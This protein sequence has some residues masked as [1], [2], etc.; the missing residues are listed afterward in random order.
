MLILALIL[1]YLLGSI[2]VGYILSRAL[3]GID[4][5]KHGSGN[6][7]A[8]NVFRVVS[9]WAGIVV[10][11]LDAL[12]GTLP[13]T[14]LGDFLMQSSP[15]LDEVLVRLLLGV[16]AVCGHNW[17]LFLKFKGGKGVATSAG[18]LLGLSFKIPQLG[19]I[20]GLC[21]GVWILILLA[22][23]FVSLASIGASVA[24]PLFMLGFNQPLKLIIFSVALCLFVVYRHKSNIGRLL[25]K[26]EKKI[27]KS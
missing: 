4:I 3:K 25:R 14:V 20:A 27:F 17:T 8:T 23:G 24:L 12:K 16:A 11:V 15:G 13:V 9:P 6:F 1:S 10:L 22:T 19:L 5:R 26:E 7:G 21:L 2:P 18:A